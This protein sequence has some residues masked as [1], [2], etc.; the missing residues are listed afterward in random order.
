MSVC[1]F[2]CLFFTLYS[3]TF[4][5]VDQSLK[6]FNMV[7]RYTKVLYVSKKF[8]PTVCS[9]FYRHIS[10]I[11]IYRLHSTTSENKRYWQQWEFKWMWI[12]ES[13]SSRIKLPTYVCYSPA[14]SPVT[15][16]YP[17]RPAR[18]FYFYFFL[19]AAR[20]DTNC[21]GYELGF[22]SC[23]FGNSF[24][25]KKYP[26]YCLRWKTLCLILFKYMII[27]QQRR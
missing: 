24:F 20:V 8:G 9:F 2:S 23:P 27:F 12:T 7:L 18:Y 3:L 13:E 5:Q 11:L 6:H 26:Q 16:F 15:G 14:S 4:I 1:L 25:V 10:K 19:V 22:D 21:F 17:T